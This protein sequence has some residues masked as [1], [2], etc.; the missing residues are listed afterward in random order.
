MKKFIGAIVS[1]LFILAP[2]IGQAQE[3][4]YMGTYI[5]I[6]DLEGGT[7]VTAGEYELIIHIDSEGGIEIIDVD[8]ISAKGTLDGN[9]FNVIRRQP[10]QIFTGTIENGR[11]EGVTTHNV[12]TGNGTLSLE[13]QEE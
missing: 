13:L 12:Y 2:A 4:P 6:E 1:I 11:I 7:A 10:L 9:S 3:N 8:G 5:G